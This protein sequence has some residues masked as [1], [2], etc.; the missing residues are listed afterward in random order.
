VC[1]CVCVCARARATHS[2]FVCFRMEFTQELLWK[3]YWNS[4]FSIRHGNS[5]GRSG[6]LGFYR[7]TD[8]LG[9]QSVSQSIS[10]SVNQSVSQS[11]SQSHL[12]TSLAIHIYKLGMIQSPCSSNPLTKTHHV[13]KR[14]ATMKLRTVPRSNRDHKSSMLTFINNVSIDCTIQYTYHITCGW[15]ITITMKYVTLR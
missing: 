14:T 13:I 12:H 8:P 15:P 2:G 6:T 9:S 4:W 3:R 5:R 7:N 11:V 1:V 10:Q